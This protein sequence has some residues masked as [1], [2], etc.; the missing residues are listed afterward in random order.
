MNSEKSLN[1]VEVAELLNITKNTV[2]ELVKRGELPGYKIGK[3]L[4]IDKQDVEEYINGQKNYN[5]IKIIGN[6][7]EHSDKSDKSSKGESDIIIAGQDSIL[8]ILSENIKSYSN[9]VRVLRNNVGS[10]TNL[11]DLYNEKI[12]LCSVHLWDGYTNE[13]NTEY[14]K[15]LLPGIPCVLINLAYRQQGFYVAKGN[16][17]NINSW[18]DLSNKHISIINREKGSG[19]RILLDEKLRINGINSNDVNGY[20]IERNS[21]LSVASSIARNE[22]D[23]GIGIEKIALS[24]KGIEFVPMQEER[25]DLVIKKDK[26][27]SEI[28]KLVLKIVKSEE[29]KSEIDGLSGYDL[30]DIGKIVAD[31]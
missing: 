30:R 17:H 9:N 12:S 15:R 1:A 28:F 14:V 6:I 13:Y 2:Y 20:N 11:Y 31:I 7:S 21:H 10:Y 8:D 18:K 22:G 27:N 25:Y 4:R 23:V 26:L 5:G 24:V 19:T 29:F 3:K 16:P